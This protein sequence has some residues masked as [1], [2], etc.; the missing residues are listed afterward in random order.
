M[1]SHQ[2]GRFKF[3]GG[4]VASDTSPG[5]HCASGIGRESN[6]A[7]LTSFPLCPAIRLDSILSASTIPPR[8]HAGL[9]RLSTLPDILRRAGN[10][11]ASTDASGGRCYLQAARAGFAPAAATPPAASWFSAKFQGRLSAPALTIPSGTGRTRTC[12]SRIVA[13]RHF[14][15]S[16]GPSLCHPTEA[17]P[18]KPPPSRTQ[19]RLRRLPPR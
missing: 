8:S 4:H 12:I 14:L 11:L 18:T 13:G 19:P 17:K 16:H 2:P 15:F 7:R 3:I 10:A 1:A 9:S 5:F 6:P